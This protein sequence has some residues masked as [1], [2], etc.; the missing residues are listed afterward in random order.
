MILPLRVA[1]T[2]GIGSGKSTVAEQFQKLGAPI[3]DSDIISREIVKPGFSVLNKIITEFG[4]RI[5]KHDGI[6]DRH[7]LRE[8]IFTDANAKKKL[9]QILHPVI[10]QKISEQ[11]PSI[12]YPYCL[13]IVPLLIETQTMNK[14]DRILVVDIPEFMQ[15]A[16]ARK[17]DKCSAEMIKSII[18]TQVKRRQR[19]KFADDI[20]DNN[21]EIN[22][23]NKSVQKLH[24]KY[25]SLQVNGNMCS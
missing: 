1:L 22:E 23:L 18:K 14:F 5:L 13:I 11:I 7:K 6:L 12:N 24:N 8:L 25:L 4:E 2:G 10:Y 20:I 3:I 21:F 16:R 15:I 17:R 9:E 19:L